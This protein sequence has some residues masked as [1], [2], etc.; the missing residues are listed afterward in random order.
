M[1]MGSFLPDVAGA[2]EDVLDRVFKIKDPSFKGVAPKKTAVK[3]A[4]HEEH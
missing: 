3:K 1:L 4:A 2:V